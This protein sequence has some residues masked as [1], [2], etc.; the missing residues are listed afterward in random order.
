MSENRL[1]GLSSL[2]HRD[3]TSIPLLNPSEDQHAEATAQTIITMCRLREGRNKLWPFGYQVI[4]LVDEPSNAREIYEKQILP[5]GAKKMRA[6]AWKYDKV[7]DLLLVKK[8]SGLV[9]YFHQFK[10][11]YPLKLMT[12][13][14]VIKREED[15]SRDLG[16]GGCLL[17]SPH[18]PQ[19]RCTHTYRQYN[20]PLS[21]SLS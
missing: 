1:F 4:R 5:V 17:P 2:N 6:L 15:K 9:L 18:Q 8:A 16:V 10:A 3:L 7:W 21:L 19:S 11:S 12:F 14:I 20:Q 13:K